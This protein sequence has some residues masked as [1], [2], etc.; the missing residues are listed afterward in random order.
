MISAIGRPMLDLGISIDINKDEME[1][2][3]I[4]RIPA[5]LI[6]RTII[7]FVR[8]RSTLRFVSTRKLYSPL[9]THCHFLLILWATYVGNFSS[10]RYISTIS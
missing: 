8:E 10:F 6:S 5:T 7:H 3:R 9:A 2:T 4:Q 1:A